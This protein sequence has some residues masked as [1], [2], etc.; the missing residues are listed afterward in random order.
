[1]ALDLIVAIGIVSFL[2]LYLAVKFKEG[3]HDL[4]KLV[5][6]FAFFILINLLSYSA[7]DTNCQLFLANE[8]VSGSVTTYEY[9]EVCNSDKTTSESYFFRLTQWIGYIFVIYILIYLLYDWFSKTEKFGK[10]LTK[11]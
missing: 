11:K 9:S 8:T 4:F 7:I 6:I 2:F 3:E 5:L 1:M 10:W